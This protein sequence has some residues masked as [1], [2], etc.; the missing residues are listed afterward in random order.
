MNKKT[1]CQYFTTNYNYILQDF[2]IPD[3]VENIIEPFCGNG[4]LLKFLKKDYN[5]EC[6]DI[7]PKQDYIKYRDTFLDE[8]D[9]TNKFV[10]T[11]PPYLARNKTNKKEVFNKYGT[12]DLYKCFIKQIIKN[13]CVGGIII[14]PLNF[15]SSVR[16]SDITLRAEFL[17]VYEVVRI[18]IFEEKVFEDT[19]Y[20]V[21]SMMFAQRTNDDSQPINITVYPSKKMINVVLNDKNNYMPGGE[22]YHL[23]NSNTYTVNRL[24]K[25]NQKNT[26]ILVKCIDD[27]ENNRI[28]LSIVKDDEVVIDNT[29]NLSNRTYATLTISPEIDLNK[30][31]VL[32]NKFNEFL[33]DYRFKYNS[34][35]LTNYRES[36]DIA[37]KRISFEL[38]YEIVK[39]LLDFLD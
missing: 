31:M 25:K 35:F 34:L 20:T 22:I 26:N 2:Y 24:T 4:D 17:K 14:I 8:P 15:W 27:N 5:L 36:S 21:C 23:T 29:K 12:N 39:H 33:N 19:S 3:Q 1:L 18:N 11:N 10:L 32:V 6:Y 38:V 9:Y 30:Q 16:M 28:S 13:K 7:E 37:R